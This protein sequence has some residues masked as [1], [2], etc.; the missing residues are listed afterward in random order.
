MKGRGVK[1]FP[2]NTTNV[3]LRLV[4][5]HMAI[6]PPSPYYYYY[7]YYYHHREKPSPTCLMLFNFIISLILGC[8]SNPFFFFFLWASPS[9]LITF[10]CFPLF[11]L[12]HWIWVPFV[13]THYFG[14]YMSRWWG[15]SFTLEYE[16]SSCSILWLGLF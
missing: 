8:S 15:W 4:S 14:R 7:Y 9:V 5:N 3:R 10:Y 11:R 16:M 6:L 12:L 2:N 1:R 13:Y